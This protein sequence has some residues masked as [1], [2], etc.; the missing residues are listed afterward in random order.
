MEFVVDG[1]VVGEAPA[2]II[3]DTRGVPD[4]P[5]WIRARAKVGSQTFSSE[6]VKV[7]VRNR[8]TPSNRVRSEWKARRLSVDDYLRWGV[9]SLTDSRLLPDR[10]QSKHDAEGDQT[11]ALYEFL[12]V[13][14]KARAE[15]KRE[16]REVLARP[17]VGVQPQ[18]RSHGVVAASSLFD[19]EVTTQHFQITYD[20]D[21][22]SA[23]DDLETWNPYANGSAGRASQSNDEPDDIDRLAFAFERA[24][25]VYANVLDFDT[26]VS[27]IEIAVTTP[28]CGEGCGGFTNPFDDHN[29]QVNPNSANI[30]PFYIARHE[31]FHAF[32][33]QYVSGAEHLANFDPNT[34]WLEGTAEWAAHQAASPI[35]DPEEARDDNDN[36]A[37]HLPVFFDAPEGRL[38]TSS[39]YS[40]GRPYGTFIFSEFLEERFDVSIV[41]RVWEEMSGP[42]NPPADEAVDTVIEFENDSLADVT[43]DFWR[44]N[45]RLEVGYQDSDRVDVWQSYLGSSERPARVPTNMEVGQSASGT[46]EIFAGGSVFVDFSPPASAGPTTLTVETTAADGRGQEDL[47]VSFLPFDD[48]PGLCSAGIS[49]GTS[50]EIDLGED[51]EFATLVLTHTN[52]RAAVTDS[53][54]V[55]WTATLQEVPGP[56]DE[57]ANDDSP[58]GYWRLGEP[59]PNPAI[60]ETG[61]P[62]GSYRGTKQGV[63]G[64]LGGSNTAITTNVSTD[65][66]VVGGRNNLNNF[67]ANKLTLEA[68][69]K[70]EWSK[71][72]SNAAIISKPWRDGSWNSPWGQY[73]LVRLPGT[74]R[75]V[76]EF[77]DPSEGYH[78][79]TS[80][81][82]LSADTWHHVA[83]TFD[84][85]TL[86]IYI[87][88]E[89]DHSSTWTGS[90]AQRSSDLAIGTR[91]DS[92]PG[93][94]WVGGIDEVAIYASALAGGRV[95]A[96]HDA[97]AANYR[98]EVMADSPV[99]Y[100][101]LGEPTPNQSIDETGN[102]NGIYKNVAQGVSGAL[103]D[104]NAAITTRGGASHVVIP[105][106]GNINNLTDELTLEAW[107]KPEWS[108]M[109]TN[110]AIISKPWRDG[111]WNSP[112]GQYGLVRLPG[113]NRLVF[114]FRDPSEGYH[115]VTSAT[116]LS[117][118]TWYHVA[119][120][121]D[122]DTL[123]IYINGELD[124]SSTWTGSIAQRS[125]DLAIGT[126]S[127]SSP[128]ESWVGGIDEVAVYD[129]AVSAE[130][131]SMHFRAASTD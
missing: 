128:G 27:P 1:V 44:A 78:S 34:W 7:F 25:G 83:G 26:P 16:V 68:W 111:S 45:Y 107:V 76:F 130:R 35:S 43:A 15:T 65:H 90:I 47:E 105:G 23:A 64:A 104:S 29:I 58:A 59:D 22:Y 88:G 60:D 73:G 95:D 8:L 38:T 91:S 66:V 4:G 77:R 48:Y 70:P 12:S 89:L 112:W 92:S 82:S 33:F 117:A 2:R 71:M 106:R 6:R 28:V 114:E 102:G 67:S 116:S 75:L 69:V 46:A 101:R 72:G 94:S 81:S 30:E 19:G 18:P 79:V 125:S 98:G 123:R 10:F 87:N 50:F 56:Y 120:T 54:E 74:N 131:V 86:R 93:E 5:H 61:N 115:S 118:D 52:P 40:I 121:F 80:A 110:A 129:H 37:R 42:S 84:G 9:L 51:C 57:E 11:D 49:S 96:H 36:Y 113:S 97:S 3:W 20:P 53:R 103:D 126:R 119:G 124:H 17:A 21:S 55:N 62:S 13:W 85:D 127:D 100:W 31:L 32:Q 108:K 39:L 109:G 122:G 99:G 24:W 14:K 63:A 41:R